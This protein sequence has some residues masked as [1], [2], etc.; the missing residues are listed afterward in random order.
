MSARKVVEDILNRSL[1]D[2]E[3]KPLTDLD[4]VGKLLALV[5]TD[6]G[7]SQWIKGFDAASALS[8][9]GLRAIGRSVRMYDVDWICV[10]NIYQAMHP[11]AGRR[12]GRLFI[13]VDEKFRQCLI[14]I[15]TGQLLVERIQVACVKTNAKEIES[16]ADKSIEL[17]SNMS[18]HAVAEDQAKWREARLVS[19]RTELQRLCRTMEKL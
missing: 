15:P 5:L 14:W 6:Q 9:L 2:S 17:S 18:K 1:L 13:S 8:W 12:I 7:K 11:V 10:P 4:N 16:I 19:Y 3:V